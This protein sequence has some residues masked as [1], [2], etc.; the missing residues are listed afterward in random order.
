MH[1]IIMSLIG[2]LIGQLLRLIIPAVVI[3]I[4]LTGVVM[5]NA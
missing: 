2:F 4:G 5:C 1:T 3:I